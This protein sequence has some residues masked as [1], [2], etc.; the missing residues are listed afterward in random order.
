MFDMDQFNVPKKVNRHVFKAVSALQ[1]SR[2]GFVSAEL[3]N[4]HV[5]RQMRRGKNVPNLDEIIHQSLANLTNLGVLACTGSSDYAIRHTIKCATDEYSLLPNPM[6]QVDTSA[7]ASA[8]AAAAAAAPRKRITCSNPVRV[9]SADSAGKVRL[10]TRVPRIRKGAV[11][12]VKRAPVSKT[13]RARAPFS[14]QRKSGQRR[15]SIMCIACRSAVMDLVKICQMINQCSSMDA[16]GTHIVAENAAESSIPMAMEI[17]PNVVPQV[18]PM[19]APSH[20]NSQGNHANN[21]T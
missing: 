16:H 18:S 21:S 14:R 7:A 15:P 9:I 13:R 20:D 11:K 10:R 4:Q 2:S 1:T 19:Y 17:E 8:S 5:K 12:A 3:I 6:C